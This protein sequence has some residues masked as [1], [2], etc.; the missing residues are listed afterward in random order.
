MN[1]KTF[2]EHGGFRIIWTECI[3]AHLRLS[4]SSRTITLLLDNSLPDQSLVFWYD[5]QSIKQYEYMLQPNDTRDPKF[6]FMYELKSAHHLLFHNSNARQF[7]PSETCAVSR[8]SKSGIMVHG[9]RVD[10][11]SSRARK[12]L[13]HLLYTP[14]L[15]H[16]SRR[17]RDEPK[18]IRRRRIWWPID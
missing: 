13:N 9:L 16:L 4:T 6:H 2:R 10:I 14:L 15:D 8:G 1:N 3:D 17:T 18:N 5:A 7:T 12:I 11:N